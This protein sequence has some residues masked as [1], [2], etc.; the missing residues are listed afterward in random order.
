[1]N[2]KSVLIS[3]NIFFI[4]TFLLL[5]L[6]CSCG[7]ATA[8]PQLE[9]AETLM[10]ERPDSSLQIL[11]SIDSSRLRGAD[12]ALYALLLTQARDKNHLDLGTDSMI[13]FAVDYYRTAGDEEHLA[14]SNYFRG[15]VRYRSGR[16]SD[17]LR[18]F[19]TAEQL[20]VKT[21]DEFIAGMSCRGMSDVYGDSYATSDQ[22]EFAKKELDHLLK[23]GKRPY[24]LSAMVDLGIAYNNAGLTDKSRAIS[25]LLEDSAL[26]HE[27]SY[28]LG[29]AYSLR[30]NSFLIEG[31]YTSV[32]PIVNKMSA[33]GFAGSQDSVCLA[34]AFAHL[35]RREEATSIIESVSELDSLHTSEV[36]EALDLNDGNY[37][38]ALRH[39]E[40]QDS[41]A[42][43]HYRNVTSESLGKVMLEHYSLQRELDLALADKK[44]LYHR[45]FICGMFVLFCYSGYYLIRLYR[46]QR[47]HR[48]DQ[49]ILAK[50]LEAELKRRKNEISEA[51]AQNSYLSTENSSLQK[52]NRT[53]SEERQTL[54][55]EN[56]GLT[57]DIRTLSEETSGLRAINKDLRCEKEELVEK[58]R[59]LNELELSNRNLSTHISDYRHTVSELQDELQASRE[60][61]YGLLLDIAQRIY[62]FGEEIDQAGYSNVVREMISEFSVGGS[63]LMQLKNE[64]DQVSGNIVSRLIEEI[65]RLPKDY[66]AIFIYMVLGFPQ[67][68]ILTFLKFS[69]PAKLYDK[70]RRLKQKVLSLPE[71]RQE[72]FLRYF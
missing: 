53:L 57:E 37:A 21:G 7:G 38:S 12:R 6:L 58:T 40:Y 20:A 66:V 64:A 15:R 62:L 22:I 60:K 11:D 54:L 16:S 23:S 43:L 33:I 30:Y 51:S 4:L 46:T 55:A 44:L 1:M 34:V 32:I 61:R 31:D 72:A 67:A 25:R 5:S 52:R 10:D 2:R 8:R 59:H 27:D 26:R 68:A 3:S 56:R 47:R 50:R 14:K 9:L 70:R 35:G 18:D 42:T 17:A 36:F 24:Y 65:P 63:R 41:V 45:L 69:S 49:E 71:D 39:S 13:T 19:A 28:Y 48:Q 29:R